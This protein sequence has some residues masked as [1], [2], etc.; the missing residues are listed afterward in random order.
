MTK[1]RKPMGGKRL[2]KRPRPRLPAKLR[3]Q[4]YKMVAFFDGK[5]KQTMTVNEENIVTLGW[6]PPDMDVSIVLVP[7]SVSHEQGIAIQKLLEANFRKPV[8][9][10]TNTTQLVRLKPISD[11]EADQ[12]MKAEGGDILQF[13]NAPYQVPQKSPA[14][15]EAE[16]GDGQE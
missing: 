1:L 6:V 3:E 10:L 9:V 15:P 16:A 7:P 5:S 4:W 12:I 8:L 11:A 13:T 2:P 14:E